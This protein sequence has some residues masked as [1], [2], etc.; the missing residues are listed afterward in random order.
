MHHAF[1]TFS[2]QVRIINEI[3]SQGTLK[4]LLWLC[5][6]STMKSL[7]ADD[8]NKNIVVYV[9][10]FY[11]EFADA[12][13]KLS[14]KLGRPLRGVM[15][16]DAERKAS[17][18]AL[19]DKDGMF[20]EIIVDFS[21]SAALHRALK[22]LED[23]LLI[24]S[25]ESERSQLYFKQVIPHVP[26]VN[27]P[28]ESSIDWATNKA[29]MREMLSSY[30][31]D[32]A[33][34]AIEVHDDSEETVRK[35]IGRLEFPLIIKPVNLNSSILVNKVND[36]AE[37]RETLTNSLT[38]LKEVYAKYRGIGD[39][40]MIVEEFVEGDTYSADGYVDAAGTTYVLPFIYYETAAKLGMEGYQ[41][42]RIESHLT[43][44]DEEIAEGQ[45]VARKAMHAIGLRSSVA[46]I[47]LFH[48]KNGWKVIEL[49]ARP[50]GHRQDM[51][52]ASYGIEHAL[53]ELL[54][55]VGLEPEIP[56][57]VKTYSET[58]I[59]YAPAAGTVESIEGIE[60]I[61]NHPQ[62]Y[63]LDIPVKPGDTVM[64]SSD[65]GNMLIYGVMHNTD[66]EQLLRDIET[67]RATIKIHLK[68]N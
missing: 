8:K 50:G 16:V 11:P 43:L 62:I 12:F 66:R 9:N 64:P 17:G 52:M 61:R 6:R 7:L 38:A 67:A 37:L 33:P 68:Q 40:T 1:S 56:T 15:L 51:Y 31:E 21:D 26:Y 34:K 49:G 57:E 10:D 4:G 28:T 36:E 5:V 22:P 65:G 47:E 19:P 13:T 44:T 63:S 24:V 14:A 53:N 41:I 55:K 30:D 29:R 54:V 27:T 42:H 45:I 23:N 3:T 59:I 60:E 58:F 35:I 18:K 32:I 20:E 39:I 46:H 25:C 48:T 2:T